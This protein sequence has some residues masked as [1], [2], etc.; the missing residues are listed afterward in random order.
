M[1]VSIGN[2]I[3][4]NKNRVKKFKDSQFIFLFF[5]CFR[6]SGTK[7][8]LYLLYRFYKHGWILLKPG[9]QVSIGHCI[10]ENEN[11]VTGISK[12]PQEWGFLGDR[13]IHM[14]SLG[15]QVI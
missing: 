12:I 5:I 15:D 4:E 2:V 9:V 8:Y 1:Q 6:T 14:R 3:I 7:K 13:G 11:R 10:I